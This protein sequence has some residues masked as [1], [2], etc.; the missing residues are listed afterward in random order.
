MIINY[1]KQHNPIYNNSGV[2]DLCRA[3]RINKSLLILDLEGNNIQDEGTNSLAQVC[4][5]VCVCVWLLIIFL[6]YFC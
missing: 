5:C 1:S 6:L 3:L 4:V 2:V